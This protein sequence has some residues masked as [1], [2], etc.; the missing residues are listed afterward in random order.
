M[1]VLLDTNFLLLPHQFGVDI[2]EYLSLYEVATLDL[3]INELKKL[4]K[5]KNEDA[6]AARIAL[7]L[8]KGK[9]VEII[10]SD[11]KKVD[12]AILNYASNERCAVATNDKE[13]IKDLKRCG[14]KI[15]RLRQNKYLIEE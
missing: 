1:K 10:K 11:E 5:G 2:F 15:I 6:K 13:L 3:C 4:S 9:N 14:I 8:I 12:S 7:K